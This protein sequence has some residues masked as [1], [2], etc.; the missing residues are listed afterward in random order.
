[1]ENGIKEWCTE[2]G[3]KPY[4][5]F[6]YE[7]ASNKWPW[8]DYETEHLKHLAAAANKFWKNFDPTDNTTAPTNETVQNFLKDK[9]VSQK[10]AESMA[11]ILRADKLPPGPRK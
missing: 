3:L 1:M 10:I 2:N 9:G 6:P 7:E 5:L 4:F 11:T 8:G